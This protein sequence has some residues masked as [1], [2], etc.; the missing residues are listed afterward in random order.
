MEAIYEVFSFESVAVS[1]EASDAVFLFVE[2]WWLVDR[3]E[4]DR[5]K[6]L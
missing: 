4:S 3:I 5:I 1:G 2:A 6:P